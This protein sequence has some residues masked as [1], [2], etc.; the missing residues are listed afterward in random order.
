[1]A[2]IRIEERKRGAPWML[3]M[4]MLVAAAAI[5]WWLWSSRSIGEPTTGSP[6]EVVADSAAPSDT[7]PAAQ[8]TP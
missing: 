5:G 3:I 8:R 7:G 1:V 2:D 4:L 6:G